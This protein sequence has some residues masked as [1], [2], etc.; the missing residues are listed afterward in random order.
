MPPE[1][2][3]RVLHALIGGLVMQRVLTPELCSHEVFYP[4]FAAFAREWEY[5]FPERARL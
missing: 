4:S 5:F 1:N 2:L 3:V